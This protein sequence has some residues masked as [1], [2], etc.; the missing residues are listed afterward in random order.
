MFQV[1]YTEV[2]TGPMYLVFV[3]FTPPFWN[4]KRFTVQQTEDWPEGELIVL[5]TAHIVQILNWM[6]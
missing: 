5:S 6:V 2:L 3:V 4:S 1:Q